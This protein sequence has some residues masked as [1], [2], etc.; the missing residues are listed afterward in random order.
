MDQA[1]VLCKQH[2]NTLLLGTSKTEAKKP[3]LIEFYNYT[4]GPFIN[5]VCTTIVSGWDWQLHFFLSSKCLVRRNAN[6]E[7]LQTLLALRT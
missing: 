2:T 1:K 3:A 6:N 5:Y 4:K 7:K